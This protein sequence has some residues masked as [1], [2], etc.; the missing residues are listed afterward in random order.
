MK[1]N[2]IQW[3]QKVLAKRS[4]LYHSNL[5]NEPLKIETVV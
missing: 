3:K 5:N 4:K 2:E 1:Y